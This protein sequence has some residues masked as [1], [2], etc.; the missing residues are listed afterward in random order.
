MAFTLL[1]TSTISVTN[2]TLATFDPT[3]GRFVLVQGSKQFLGSF[4][5]DQADNTVTVLIDQTS[6][7]GPS[8]TSGAAAT[9][10]TAA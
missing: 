6:R 3:L 10:G 2:G 9:P 4:F 5:V 8:R 7:P 1:N